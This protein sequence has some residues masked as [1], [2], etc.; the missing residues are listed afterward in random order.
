M[1]E[2]KLWFVQ[3]GWNDA[4]ANRPFAVEAEHYQHAVSY[5]YGRLL[6]AEMRAD[7]RNGG[8]PIRAWMGKPG[9]IP[10]Q[11][12]QAMNWFP[13]ALPELTEAQ[14]WEQENMHRAKK[15]HEETCVS[16]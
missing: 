16:Y 9:H 3:K 5:E 6:V 15:P 12:F 2:W 10:D 11:V 4:V 8:K 1:T 13:E 14:E 7:A